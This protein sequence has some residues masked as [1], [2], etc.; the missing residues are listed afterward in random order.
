MIMAILSD[1]GD[2][3]SFWM[4]IPSGLQ[5]DAGLKSIR[6][7]GPPKKDGKNV[8]YF[9]SDL[10]VHRGS[11]ENLD[12]VTSEPAWFIMVQFLLLE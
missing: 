6:I 8:H 11:R 2:H 3:N 4:E 5:R 9:D 10:F 7:A 12:T 1:I